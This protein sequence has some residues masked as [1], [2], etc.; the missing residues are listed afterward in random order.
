MQKQTFKLS[1]RLQELE[2]SPAP[3]PTVKC[4]EVRR[5]QRLRFKQ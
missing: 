2:K 5:V 1:R 4:D 3:E